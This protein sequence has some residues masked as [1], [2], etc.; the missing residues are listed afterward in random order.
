MEI[1][2]DRRKAVSAVSATSHAPLEDA[3][4]AIDPPPVR[5][6]PAAGAALRS[7]DAWLRAIAGAAAFALVAGGTPPTA[8]ALALVGVASWLGCAPRGASIAA[9]LV[10]GLAASARWD[11]A[12]AFLAIAACALRV[13]IHFGP[14][15][16][17]LREVR[18][19]EQRRFAALVATGLARARG[20]ADA[21]RIAGDHY[22]REGAARSA[23]A[24][25]G[26]VP[27]RWLD[28]VLGASAWIGTHVQ[29]WPRL[30]DVLE[31]RAAQ[32]L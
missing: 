7:A 19:L 5:P 14:A 12:A 17:W 16:A 26:A 10:V 6:P 20:G 4:R 21:L 1:R 13:R 15:G 32:S 3:H 25:I 11:G 23:L 2:R 8:V 29:R 18:G 9:L 27:S 31:R 24:A 28:P 22:E 30:R